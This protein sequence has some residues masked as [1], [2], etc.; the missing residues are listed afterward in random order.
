MDA[1]IYGHMEYNNRA[2]H[3]L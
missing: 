1:F 3:L 2:F